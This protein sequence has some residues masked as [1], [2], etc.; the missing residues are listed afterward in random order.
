MHA[1]FFVCFLFAQTVCSHAISFVCAP[2]TLTQSRR[3][4][5]QPGINELKTAVIQD[6]VAQI[7]AIVKSNPKLLTLKFSQAKQTALHL[8]VSSGKFEATQ[9]LIELGAS[10]TEKD[11]RKQTPLHL[12]INQADVR[13]ASVLIENSDDLN[14]VDQNGATPLMRVVMN[15]NAKVELAELMI[16]KGADLDSVNRGKQSALHLA[17][18]YRRPELG[19]KLIEAGADITAVDNNQNTPL[20]AACVSSSKLVKLLLE[21]GVDPKTVNRQGQSTLHLACR[22]RQ[23]ESV[24]LLLDKFDD[25]DLMDKQQQTPLSLAV[26][27]GSTD[28]AKALLERGADPNRFNQPENSRYLNPLVCYG[29]ASG[30]AAMLKVLLDGGAMVNV[31]NSEG[32]GPLHLACQAGGNIFDGRRR[33]GNTRQ[34]ASRFVETIE[35]L[36]SRKADQ[37]QKNNAGQTPLQV[38]ARRDFFEAVEI[39]VEKTDELDFDLGTGSL[40]HW[41][42]LNGLPKTARHLLSNERTEIDKL[43]AA[44]RS[45]IQIAAE[46]GQSEMVNLLVENNATVDQVA[47]DGATALLIASNAGHAAVVC[48]LINAGADLSRLD[49]SGQS[50]LHLAAWN[51]SEEVVKTLLAEF[52]KSEDGGVKAVNAKTQSGYTA[53]HAAAWNGHGKVV[54]ILLDAKSNPNATDSD[55]WTPIHKAAY[56]GHAESVKHLLAYGTDKGLK[57]SVGMT[58]LEMAQGNKKSAVVELLK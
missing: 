13:I 50:C 24:K 39:L 55:G 34:A 20:L 4:Q 58:A 41:A 36:L 31:K 45:S 57:N 8:A 35:L 2:T 54:K 28:A 7:E 10:A 18:Y 23:F 1:F 11:A 29:A 12:A 32:D 16:K 6:N 14:V 42:A 40:L 15:R 48:S 9:K 25:V 43:D 5:V 53:L 30:N 38:A 49:A 17:C 19:V 37:N 52:G 33:G 3:V 27:A 44:G 47:A 46:N 26:I 56:R 21:K 51:G 22:S